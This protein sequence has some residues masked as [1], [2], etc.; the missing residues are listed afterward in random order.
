[1]QFDDESVLELLVAL[2]PLAVEHALAPGLGIAQVLGEILVNH[3]GEI[4]Q[5]VA[6]VKDVGMRPFGFLARGL[7]VDPASG[8]KSES[9]M[10]LR[11]ST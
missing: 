1:M 7:G 2:D 11:P 10:A 3:A 6:F 5:A 9:P 4:D 8:V